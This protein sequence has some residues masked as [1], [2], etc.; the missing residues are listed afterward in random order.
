MWRRTARRQ[1]VAAWARRLRGMLPGQLMRGA[2]SR[3]SRPVHDP[4]LVLL[5]ACLA[6]ITG[7]TFGDWELCLVDDGSKS[8][9]VRSEL[10]RLAAAEPRVKLVE[11]PVAGGIVAASNEGLAM[12]TGEFVVLVDHDDRLDPR[13][14]ELVDAALSGDDE[15]DYVYTDED[16]LARRRHPPR[17]VLQARLVA[18][19][20]AVTELLHAPLGAAT[21]D[22]RG[23]GRLPRGVR[24]LAGPRPDP[25]GDRARAAR[26][27]R[28]RG[29][30]PL[31]RHARLGGRRLGRCPGRQAARPGGRTACRRRAHGAARHR[32]QRREPPDTRPLPR[33]A[34]ATG[35][36]TDGERDHLDERRDRGRSG[37]SS[38]RWW[39]APCSRCSA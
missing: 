2:A 30:L 32:G 37:G 1:R 4:P 34:G 38:G 27:P 16:K 12:A 28:A 3:S 36:A 13:A 26:P 23:G 22:R 18:G 35:A 8:A 9:A 25:A 29:A 15:I 33:P 17:H 7:Q 31:V 14:L 11:R 39:W 19:A 6:S 20:A 5:D 21:P 24:R 10:R